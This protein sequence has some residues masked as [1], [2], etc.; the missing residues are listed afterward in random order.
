VTDNATVVLVHGAWHGA[1]C[2]DKVVALLD[3]AGVTSVAVELPFTSY[4]DD[5]AAA[6]TAVTDVGGPVVLC[7]HSYG[8]AV[9]TGAGDQPNVQRLVYLTAFACEEGESL[10]NTAP[11][12]G[13]T[14]IDLDGLLVIDD[15]DTTVT[16]DPD[17][18]AAVFYHDCATDDVASA[19]AMVRSMQLSCLTAPVGEPAWRSKPST[20][21]VCTEDR[22]VHPELQRV[23]AARCTESVDF[24]TAH[25]PFL[26][27]PDLVAGLLV[28]LA[29]R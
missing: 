10:A 14:T 4:G 25:S 6:A 13:V 1:W 19:L 12:A 17:R 28:E 26:N 15:D 11:D 29:Q 18:T 8:G 5:V 22:A 9:I 21:V 16:L 2:W 20:Y 24:P 7:G 27:R 23:M 3:D